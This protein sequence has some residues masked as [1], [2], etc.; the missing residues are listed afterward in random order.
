MDDSAWYVD[1]ALEHAADALRRCGD[2]VRPAR[3]MQRGVPTGESAG[4]ASER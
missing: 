3:L 1:M 4:A 2:L